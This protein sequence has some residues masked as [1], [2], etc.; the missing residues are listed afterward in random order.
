MEL[1]ERRITRLYFPLKTVVGNNNIFIPVTICEIYFNYYLLGVSEN[2]FSIEVGLHGD[3][4]IP[5]NKDYESR[6][7]I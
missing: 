4:W 6:R 7:K 1:I 3:R 5:L 2:L